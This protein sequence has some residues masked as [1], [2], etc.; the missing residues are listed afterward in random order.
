MLYAA[1]AGGEASG[2]A[3]AGPGRREGGRR[4]SE[5]SGRWWV[6]ARRQR[7]EG[8]GLA[9]GP[10]AEERERR[11]ERGRQ[12]MVGVFFGLVS[13]SFRLACSRV[14]C[15]RFCCWCWSCLGLGFG[16]SVFFLFSVRK[17]DLG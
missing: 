13:F 12:T 8:G 17:R 3:V 6:V 10:A 14:F 15:L 16:N 4:R 2:R 1:L 7:P 9:A 5:A 11:S